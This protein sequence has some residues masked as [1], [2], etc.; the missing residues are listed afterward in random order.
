MGEILPPHLSPFIDKDKDQQYIPPEAR[1]LYSENELEQQFKMDEVNKD[2]S[3]EDVDDADGE[4]EE[5]GDEQGDNGN[6]EDEDEES[7]EI[8]EDE[9][10]AEG[11]GSKVRYITLSFKHKFFTCH[12]FYYCI[13]LLSSG[14]LSYARLSTLSVHLNLNCCYSKS[15]QPLIRSE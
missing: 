1:A 2:E 10:G 7:D 5:D 6:E 14:I 9:D 12:L 15:A 11:H 8:Q 4:E 13:T 3:K